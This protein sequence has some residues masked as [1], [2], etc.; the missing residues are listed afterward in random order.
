[1]LKKVF[2]W[3]YALGIFP[4]FYGLAIGFWYRGSTAD[5]FK[6]FFL[7]A[8]LFL[9]FSFA[10]S[11]A[12]LWI[13]DS[14]PWPRKVYSDSR[15][16]SNGARSSRSSGDGSSLQSDVPTPPRRRRRRNKKLR[17]V[18]A[19]CSALLFIGSSYRLLTSY[20]V[21]AAERDMAVI[22][23][24]VGDSQRTKAATVP[25]RPNPVEQEEMMFALVDVPYKGVTI[26]N[27]DRLIHLNIIL[28][29]TSTVP[30]DD[31]HVKIDSNA[32]LQAASDEETV[33]SSTE[34]G[35]RL[36]EVAPMKGSSGE[37]SIP[38]TIDLPEYQFETGLLI[39]IVGD[40]LRPYAAAA[41]LRVIDE[42]RPEPSPV[43]AKR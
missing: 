29:N 19:A 41:K 4:V 12:A 8:G 9:V 22:E 24:Y 17:K 2:S 15:R 31:A 42:T 43:S 10:W 18:L 1:M 20:R 16:S 6:R 28:R 13:N 40:N 32:P 5:S 38:V 21:I 26:H 25:F 36:L 11:L 34:L 7:A 35:F 27:G 14:F 33:L 23:V 37:I 39:S 30:I 3:E